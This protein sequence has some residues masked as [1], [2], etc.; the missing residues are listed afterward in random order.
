V[1]A[2][3]AKKKRRREARAA[4]GAAGGGSSSLRV[5]A[6]PPRGGRPAPRERGMRFEVRDGV[7]RPKP[8]WSPYPISEALLVIGIA[9]FLLGFFGGKDNSPVLIGFGAAVLTVVVAE[10]CIREHFKGFRSHSL[11]L[12]ILA[13]AAVHTFLYFVV[14]KGWRGPPAFFTDLVGIGVLSLVF[15]AKYRSAHVRAREAR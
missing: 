12:A 8:P 10:L 1:P 11:L 5:P 9:V 6:S 7:A 13:V 3:R 15:Y 2:S 14:S 4:T